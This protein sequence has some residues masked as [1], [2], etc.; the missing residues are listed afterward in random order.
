IA[1]S[2]LQAYWYAGLQQ[3]ALAFFMAGDR[4]YAV[5][6]LRKAA[7][8]KRQFDPAFWMEDEGF[9]ALGLDADKRQIRSLASNAGHLLAT[10]IVPQ[11]K[12]RRVARRLMEPDLFSGWGIRTLSSDHPAYNPFSYHLGS[13]WPVENG[14]FALG[15]GRYGCVAELHRL[16]EGIFASTDL[17]VENRL[18]EAIG[19][20]P[21]DAAHPHPGIYP[22]ANEPQGWSAS[23]IVLLVQ[24]L[25]GMRPMAPLGLLLVDPHLPPWLPDLRLTGVRV[26]TSLLDLEFRRTNSG[27]TRYWVTR[28]VGRVR[29]PTAAA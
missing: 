5:E 27:K 2:E 3:V 7:D 8:L 26:G 17:F 4:G 29:A 13:V 15:F 20:L 11:E 9:Y 16:T 10:G 18:P 14:T 25:L 24:S 12:G 6:L 23:M 28:Q 21:R 1:T 19:G 22:Q